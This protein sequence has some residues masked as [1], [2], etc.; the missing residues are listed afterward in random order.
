MDLQNSDAIHMPPEL[1]AK[2]RSVVFTS[3][4]QYI[5]NR[6]L[7]ISAVL[8]LLVILI[9]GISMFIPSLKGSLRLAAL[10]IYLFGFGLFCG[11]GATSALALA[12]L[13]R[14][15]HV[16]Q[17]DQVNIQ[18]VQD[19]ELIK[20]LAGSYTLPA[21]QRLSRRV[22]F[23]I[24]MNVRFITTV[25]L[26]AGLGATITTVAGA[27]PGAPLPVSDLLKIAIPALLLGVTIAG[28]LRHSF[29]ERLL[30][31]EFAIGEAEQLLARKEGPPAQLR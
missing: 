10:I 9:A 17:T 15:P 23:E 2:A 21:L 8:C 19:E 14:R 22:A 6:L 3:R 20:L 18:A 31:L 25:S 11:W 5:S 29:G 1:I 24:K 4:L 28:A 30:R 27:L 16:L 26:T 7:A 13:M 12:N